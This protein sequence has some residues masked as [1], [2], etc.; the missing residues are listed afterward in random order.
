VETDSQIVDFILPSLSRDLAVRARHLPATTRRGLRALGANAATS[1][2]RS[3]H[4]PVR[5]ALD[6][7]HGTRTPPGRARRWREG[8]GASPR[9]RSWRRI[10]RRAGS[11]D[12]F[13]V[14]CSDRGA[15]S[16]PAGG[17]VVCPARGPADAST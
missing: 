7:H 11:V 16:C 8:Q 12:A 1:P 10:M 9:A 13:T 4:D 15:V 5:R 17:A 6:L 2:V 14:S 3:I